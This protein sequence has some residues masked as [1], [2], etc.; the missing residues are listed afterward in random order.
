MQGLF[1]I[2]HRHYPV[3][4][5]ED[6]RFRY[7]TERGTFDVNAGIAIVIP[8][9][10]ILETLCRRIQVAKRKQAEEALGAQSPDPPR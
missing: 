10:T 6:E 7:F 1:G 5:F 2:T 4:K 8:S 9:W 3:M